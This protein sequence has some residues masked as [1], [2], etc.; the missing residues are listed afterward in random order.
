MKARRQR[1]L[2]PWPDEII[3]AVVG[4]ERLQGAAHGGP[5]REDLRKEASLVDGEPHGR[6]HLSDRALLAF[7]SG[8][9][10]PHQHMG[11]R[12]KQGTRHQGG[13]TQLIQALRRGRGL[14]R[15]HR[16]GLGQ[17]ADHRLS[18]GMK[19]IGEAPSYDKDRDT[20]GVVRAHPRTGE[21]ES[22]ARD[23]DGSQRHHQ[24]QMKVTA[25]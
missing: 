22:H 15:R 20:T 16:P 14:G 11:S 3:A 1:R 4:T 6:S 25:A 8:Q 7:R 21:R 13:S 10:S 5:G 2:R 12:H 18:L 23:P 19:G 17:S 9:S 24:G